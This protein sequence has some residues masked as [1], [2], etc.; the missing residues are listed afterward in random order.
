M[1]SYIIC[2]TPRTGSTLLC[3]LLAATKTCGAPDSY[4][5]ANADPHW[6]KTWGMPAEGDPTD[7]GYSAAML[8][9]AIKSGTASTDV[10]GL[11][12]MRSD[13]P[14]LSA[15]IDK[16]HP[17]RSSD[18]A[19]FAAAFGDVLYIHLR[20]RDKLAQ[21]VSL[22]K[23]EQTGLWHVA[24]DG[25][26]V[27]RLAPPAEPVYDHARIAT[28]LANLE[29]DDATWIDWFVAEAIDPLTV[30]YENLAAHPQEELTRI[31]TRLSVPP[32]KSVKSNLA[33]MADAVSEDWM[34]RFEEEVGA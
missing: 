20:R 27:E 12:L 13:L 17:G 26:E 21:A 8:Q 6:L 25:T 18:S 19:R 9:G 11:R 1:K 16:T 30:G 31:C 3:D 4:F 10:F 33:K 22:V 32:P 34:R 15:L 24:P 7:P 5:M 28:K 2:A 29:A 14:A 23:A